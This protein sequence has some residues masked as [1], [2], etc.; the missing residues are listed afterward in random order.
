M[1]GNCQG[2][3]IELLEQTTHAGKAGR[4]T[5]ISGRYRL[6]SSGLIL[7]ETA[8]GKCLECSGRIQLARRR[9]SVAVPIVLADSYICIET[10]ILQTFS[11][12]FRVVRNGL[13]SS[14]DH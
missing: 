5:S 13:K 12:G 1:E 11:F 14:S 9:S 10:S 6:V 4:R 2:I 3:I 8:G 7:G